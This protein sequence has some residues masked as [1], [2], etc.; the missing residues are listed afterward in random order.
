[1]GRKKPEVGKHY[2]AFVKE[3]VASVDDYTHVVIT[4]DLDADDTSEIIVDGTHGDLQG[5]HIFQCEFEPGSRRE[6][7]WK[8]IT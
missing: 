4:E 8:L 1:M 3:V 5:I 6:Y 7:R 2:A